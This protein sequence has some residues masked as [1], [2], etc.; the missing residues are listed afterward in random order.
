M[1]QNLEN[2]R[3][4]EAQKR[5]E[6]SPPPRL[7]GQLSI[8]EITGRIIA[9]CIEIYRELEPGVLES[10]FKLSGITVGLLINFNVP[11]LKHGVKRIVSNFQDFSAPPRLRG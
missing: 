8:N 3:G 10:A 11:V 9:A 7:G 1:N 4:A 6:P 2:H 5:N